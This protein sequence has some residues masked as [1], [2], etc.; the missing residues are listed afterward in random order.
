MDFFIES[1]D[2]KQYAKAKEEFLMHKEIVDEFN[3]YWDFK[4]EN[5]P[6][7]LLALSAKYRY[8]HL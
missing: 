7:E 8:K 5:Y 6:E 4:P 3:F 2:Q 1:Q